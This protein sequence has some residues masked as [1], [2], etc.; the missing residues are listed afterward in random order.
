[1]AVVELNGKLYCTDH[2][3]C[4][5]QYIDIA[6]LLLKLVVEKRQQN[7]H[8]STMLFDGRVSS[9]VSDYARK[10]SRG[11]LQA[12]NQNKFRPKLYKV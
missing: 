9:H 11:L 8:T 7:S 12:F 6:Y 2:G 4:G 5:I 3:I 10:T 1:M